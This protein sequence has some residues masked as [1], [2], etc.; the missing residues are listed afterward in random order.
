MSGTDIPSAEVT[1]ELIAN[2]KV[3]ENS[4]ATP[5]RP[6]VITNNRKLRRLISD[7]ELEPLRKFI[8]HLLEDALQAKKLS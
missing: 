3:S 1:S 4:L 6:T 8:S 7:G 2:S 5:H